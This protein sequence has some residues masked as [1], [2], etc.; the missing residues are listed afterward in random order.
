MLLEMNLL[1][2]NPKRVNLS[3]CST[4]IFVIV[5]SDKILFIFV[6]F[7]LSLEPISVTISDTINPLAAAKSLSRS[8]WRSRSSI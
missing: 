4:N 8:T 5:L 3:L 7:W 2:Q 6:L 1:N